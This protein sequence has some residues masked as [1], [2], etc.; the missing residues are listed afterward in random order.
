MHTTSATIDRAEFVGDVLDIAAGGG[1]N[2]WANVEDH[3]TTG[4]R[5]RSKDDG[6][7]ITA[8]LATVATAIAA[9]NDGC[10]P[11]RSEIRDLILAAWRNS[12][13]TNIDAEIADVIIQIGGF[14]AIVYG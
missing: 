8:N 11:V 2:Y 13:A 5:L 7:T 4:L 9:L 3:T 6:E 14:G 10:T 12:D 1:I